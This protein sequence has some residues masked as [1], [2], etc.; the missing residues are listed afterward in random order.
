MEGLEQRSGEGGLQ[1]LG[2]DS[3]LGINV[4]LLYSR[5]NLVGVTGGV[6]GGACSGRAQVARCV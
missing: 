5:G 4:Y 1:I 6:I 2:R 3:R